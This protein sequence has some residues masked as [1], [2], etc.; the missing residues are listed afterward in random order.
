VSADLDRI[1][2]AL[3]RLAEAVVSIVDSGNVHLNLR[4]SLKG[5]ELTFEIGLPA[6]IWHP[7]LMNALEPD[8]FEFDASVWRSGALGL[9]AARNLAIALGGR[10]NAHTDSLAGSRIVVILSVGAS[11]GFSLPVQMGPLQCYTRAS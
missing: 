4:S 11:T 9:A 1:G 3:L 5:T 6:R 8:Q 2:H 10:V 7:I